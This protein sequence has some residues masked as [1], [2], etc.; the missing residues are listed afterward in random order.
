MAGRRQRSV[1][2]GLGAALLMTAL[3]GVA[4]PSASALLCGYPPKACQKGKT[5]PV[6]DA[7]VAPGIMLLGRDQASRVRVTTE[8]DTVTSAAKS[9]RNAEEIS[10]RRPLRAAVTTLP[11][12]S[13]VLVFITMKDGKL[14]PIGVVATNRRGE[15]ILPAV[16]FSRPGMQTIVVRTQA[17][18]ERFASFRVTPDAF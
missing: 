8:A 13:T 4:A 12:N 16:R 3:A 5:N 7:T 17:G 6:N 15:A 18:V 14:A 10:P 11:P 2:L 9:Y 1:A